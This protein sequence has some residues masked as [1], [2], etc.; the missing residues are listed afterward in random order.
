VDKRLKPSIGFKG[1][2]L[3]PRSIELYRFLDVISEVWE[4]SSMFPISRMYNTSKGT[5]ID[6][7]F[8]KVLEPTPGIP[9]P[10]F[11]RFDQGSHEGLLRSQLAKYG[12]SV[13]FDVA[14]E[15]LDQHEDHVV[16]H[17]AKGSDQKETA[18]FA[19]VISADGGKGITRKLLGFPFLGDTHSDRGLFGD[20]RV[21]EGLDRNYWHMWQDPGKSFNML[22]YVLLPRYYLFLLSSPQ[23]KNTFLILCAKS[24]TGC[25]TQVTRIFLES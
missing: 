9:Y 10:N 24:Q 7:H 25:V 16:V 6:F 12:C 20:I 1:S 18:S 11:R 21:E 5:H 13:E 23:T 17:L 2:G 22:A 8:A 15:S 3:Q 14:L 4:K 19:Y